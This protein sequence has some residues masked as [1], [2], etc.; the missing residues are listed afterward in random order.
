MCTSLTYHPHTCIAKTPNICMND[1]V[2]LQNSEG[3]FSVKELISLDAKGSHHS[4]SPNPTNRGKNFND[5]R[6]ESREINQMGGI[7]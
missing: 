6:D 4:P 1:V 7:I 3:T 5:V 2:A